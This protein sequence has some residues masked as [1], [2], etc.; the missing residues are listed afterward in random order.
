M[1]KSNEEDGLIPAFV[2]YQA[3]SVTLSN[4]LSWN[5]QTQ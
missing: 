1:V 5:W 3:V 4:S 2:Y